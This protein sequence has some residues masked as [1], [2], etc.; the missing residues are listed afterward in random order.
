MTGPL[1]KK[2]KPVT[3]EDFVAM[4]YERLMAVAKDRDN[5]RKR[6]QEQARQQGKSYEEIMVSPPPCL[7]INPSLPVPYLQ[8][9][10]HIKDTLG[11]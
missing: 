9:N 1:A 10:L 6:A 11:P 8:W 3:K 2:D 4:V 5:M 7:S